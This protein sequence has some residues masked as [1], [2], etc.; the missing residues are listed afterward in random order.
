MTAKPETAGTSPL[1]GLRA[2]LALS[3]EPRWM[4]SITPAGRVTRPLK[5]L[6]L[7]PRDPIHGGGSSFLVL[8]RNLSQI[9]LSEQQ[10][11]R[12]RFSSQTRAGSSCAA[13][14][15]RRGIGAAFPPMVDSR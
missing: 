7:H 2:W 14:H 13:S 15:P 8:L 12:G 5:K 3:L 11:G 10:G 6:E 1:F 4:D 9:T